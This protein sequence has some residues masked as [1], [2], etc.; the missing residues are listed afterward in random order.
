MDRPQDD[1]E[2]RRPRNRAGAISLV[3]L[4][5]LFVTSFFRPPN[6]FFSVVIAG[7]ALALLAAIA[8]GAWRRRDRL[9][10]GR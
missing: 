1:L 10:G 7:V 4:A 2:L 3:V 9:S 8:I 5:G 6:P